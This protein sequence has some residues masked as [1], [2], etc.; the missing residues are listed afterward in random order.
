MEE[1]TS[2]SSTI[3]RM[4]DLLREELK[5][6]PDVVLA[7]DEV[8]VGGE[9]DLDSLDVLLIISSVE[10]EF[11]IKIANEKIGKDVFRDLSTLSQFIDDCAAD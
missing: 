5:L 9:H 11:G 1:A 2:N 7:D 4:K 10:K 6:G 8:L 3:H